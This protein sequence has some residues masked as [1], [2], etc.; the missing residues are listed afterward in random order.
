MVPA[1]GP[2]SEVFAEFRRLLPAGG[3]RLDP[4]GRAA[5]YAAASAEDVAVAVAT[6]EQRLYANLLVTIGVVPPAGGP[7]RP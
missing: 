4:L 5:F 6:G 1:E 3:L 7:P 2:E